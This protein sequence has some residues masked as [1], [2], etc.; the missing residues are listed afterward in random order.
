[1]ILVDLRQQQYISYCN[2][3][4]AERRHTVLLTTV[5]FSINITLLCTVYSALYT[6]RYLNISNKM[7]YNRA[8]VV[9]LKTN[10]LRC[11]K[12]AAFIVYLTTA[13]Y[14]ITTFR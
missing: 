9:R 10:E 13:S 7:A 8:L 12:V 11:Y 2:S 14:T 6:R 1:M 3:R 4:K 5:N